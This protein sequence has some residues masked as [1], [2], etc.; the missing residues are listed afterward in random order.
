MAELDAFDGAKG[1]LKK[2]GQK[3]MSK[4]VLRSVKG[5]QLFRESFKQ[6]AESIE[7]NFQNSDG[8]QFS[9]F[10]HTEDIFQVRTN[11][12]YSLSISI[13]GYFSN[14][15][16]SGKLSAAVFVSEFG[17]TEPRI[18]WK[19]EYVPLISEGKVLWRESLDDGGKPLSGIIL[20]GNFMKE[21]LSEI[22]SDLTEY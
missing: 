19:E 11:R 2:L 21:L 9:F 16:D 17:E 5:V 1:I 20:A 6:I 15:A 12:K 3:Q 7:D 14:S 18:F 8:I 13:H 22:E 10:R 4:D